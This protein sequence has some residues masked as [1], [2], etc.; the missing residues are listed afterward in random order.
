MLLSV[1]NL[2]VSLQD[3]LDFEDEEDEEEFP[4]GLDMCKM[5]FV[6]N[7]ELNM[8]VG[9]VAAQCAHAAVALYRILIDQPDK[10]GVI[11]MNWEQFGYG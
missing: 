5:V 9:K 8:G 11:L 6:V 10:Y 3:D 2:Y 7:M 1:S 4:D